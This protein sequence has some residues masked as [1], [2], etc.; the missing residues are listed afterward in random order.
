MFIFGGLLM[1]KFSERIKEFR[2]MSGKT[3]KEFAITLGI[4]ERAYQYYESGSREPTASKLLEIATILG[5]PAGYL[6]G[7][8]IDNTS[9]SFLSERL[10]KLRKEKGFSED[11][12]SSVI[13]LPLAV[14]KS[15]EKGYFEPN[16]HNLID[17]STL[18]EISIDNLIGITDESK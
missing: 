11:Y 6:L 10:M 18:Y 7:Q 12:V 17:L 9:N 14:Y 1:S 2:A 4:G 16:I 3:Q 5:V 13:D 15:F 8:E